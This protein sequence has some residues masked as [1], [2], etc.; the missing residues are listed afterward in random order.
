MTE[1][2]SPVDQA[3]DLLFF[4]PL[5]LALTAAEE[6]P[7]LI[8]KGRERATSQAGLYRMMGQFAV[9]EGQQRAERLVRQAQERLGDLGGNVGA[10]SEPAPAPAPS[11]AAASPNGNGSHAGIGNSNGSNG[12][13]ASVGPRPSSDA[14]A[15]PGYDTLSAP[16]V[17]QRLAGLSP[18]ELEAVRAYETATRGRKTIL[19]RV[20]QL[21][22]GA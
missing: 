10:R 17:V 11:E 5:G 19:S 15:I 1:R 3:L 12:A 20:A 9:N 2:K 7:K 21:Q 16:Q 22:S 6:L 8:E 14:L 4:A 13:G 18:D